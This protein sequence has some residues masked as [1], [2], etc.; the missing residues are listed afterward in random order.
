LEVNE[1][2]LERY[3][4]KRTLLAIMIF[5]ALHALAG[6]ISL[7]REHLELPAVTGNHLVCIWDES[8]K[9][10]YTDF[11]PYDHSGT[12]SFQLPAWGRWYWV[13]LWDEHA[14]KYVFGKW[15]GHFFS[16]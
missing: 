2:K 9:D 11:V 3:T 15:I 8:A 12:L 14:E 13:G 7:P 6:T 16:E 5:T 10:W 4:M 1:L